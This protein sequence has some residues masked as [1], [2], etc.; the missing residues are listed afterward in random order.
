MVELPAFSGKICYKSTT[1]VME[2]MP[3]FLPARNLA[4]S[5]APLAKIALEYA[6]WLKVS[7]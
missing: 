2:Y 5:R 4:A 6:V 1:S 7:T 3:G